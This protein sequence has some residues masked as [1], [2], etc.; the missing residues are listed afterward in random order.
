[1][2]KRSATNYPR[3]QGLPVRQ[4]APAIRLP[5]RVLEELVHRPAHNDRREL[6]RVVRD[7]PDTPELCAYF[8]IESHGQPATTTRARDATRTFS[9]IFASGPP[10]PSPFPNTSSAVEFDSRFWRARVVVVVVSRQPCS[11]CGLQNPARRTYLVV[12]HALLNVTHRG[13]RSVRVCISK[14]SVSARHSVGYEKQKRTDGR[15]V[16]ENLRAVDADPVERRVRE[17]IATPRRSN[18]LFQPTNDGAPLTCCS[19]ASQ[20]RQRPLAQKRD[21]GPTHHDNFCV[22]K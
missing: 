3:R 8:P 14:L 9:S 19:C 15:H 4:R 5:L 17:H 11:P 13:L 12:A 22:K 16:A 10:P 6:A 7:S 21:H 20:R 2:I 1:M 18:R